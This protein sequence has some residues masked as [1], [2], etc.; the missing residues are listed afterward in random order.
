MS[1]KPIASRRKQVAFDRAVYEALE[2]LANER[3]FS[4]N[5]LADEAFREYLKKHRRPINLQ[6]A[7]RASVRML[8][9]NDREPKSR[10]KV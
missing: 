5:R 7:L 1:V 8:P 6:D 2:I 4:V 10:R 3:G 9:A